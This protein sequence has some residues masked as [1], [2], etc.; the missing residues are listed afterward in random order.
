MADL[1]YKQA[2][3]GKV[4]A[5]TLLVGTSDESFGRLPIYCH[6]LELANPGTRTH[7]LRDCSNRFEMSFVAIGA[8]IRSFVR[9]LWPVIIIDGAHMKGSFKGT[10][11]LA[12]GMDGNNKIF[13]IA[14]GV[15]KSESSDSWTWFLSRL[16]ECECVGDHP[17]LAIISDRAKSI[18]IGISQAFPLAYQGFCCRH[19]MVNL[20]LRGKTQ[21]RIYWATCKAYRRSDFKR[22]YN[23]LCSNQPS[24]KDTFSKIGF[25]K[26]A[27][28]YS[29]VRRY[30]IMTS[31]SAESVNALSLQERKYPVTKLM[32]YFVELQ[33]RWFFERRQD[34]EKWTH[35]LSKWAQSRT[36][37]KMAKSRSW[38]ATGIDEY[39]YDVDDGGR[40]CVVDLLNRTCECRKWQVSG[41]PCGHAISVC[42]FLKLRDC[43]HLAMDYYT[44]E[45]VVSTYLEP[46][47]PV[48]N[49]SEWV[50]PESHVPL[51]PPVMEKRQAGRPRENKRILS[52]GEVTGPIFCTRCHTTGHKTGKCK[53][54]LES[55]VLRSRKKAR[56]SNVGS[57][58]HATDATQS[59][60]MTVDLNAF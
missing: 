4:Y 54:P 7:I 59:Q 17:N 21:Q 37:R 40:R 48:P 2:W 16:R 20:R 49:E 1:S 51:L 10:M 41:L 6:N 24:M 43:S 45:F 60:A 34:A 44:K 22:S 28:S 11:F 15:G 5:E 3:A 47:N 38:K 19:L 12:V 56:T 14:F 58:F 27:R 30:N 50:V 57:S 46:I 9:C 42:K 35:S 52:R 26:W 23:L 32:D 31:N 13:P 36:T 33:R 55:Q 8:A 53:Q 25:G 39:H 29:P 18:E